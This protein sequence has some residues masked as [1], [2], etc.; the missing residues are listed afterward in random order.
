MTTPEQPK[1]AHGIGLNI[2]TIKGHR[3]TR[4]QIEDRLNKW[5][6]HLELVQ[7]YMPGKGFLPVQVTAALA[8]C[9]KMIDWYDTLL[10]QYE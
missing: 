6:H 3:I 2:E 8:E 9:D 10:E 5:E 4:R 1:L 7:K